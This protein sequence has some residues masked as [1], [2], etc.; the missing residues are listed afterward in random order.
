MSLSKG[1]KSPSAKSLLELE[2]AT[3]AMNTRNSRLILRM[4]VQIMVAV[5]ALMIEPQGVI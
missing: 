5:V 3:H 1:S 2:K 4:A